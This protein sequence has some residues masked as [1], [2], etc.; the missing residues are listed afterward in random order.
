MIIWRIRKA[1][2]RDLR[3][4]VMTTTRRLAGLY[5]AARVAGTELGHGWERP[6]TAT[7]KTLLLLTPEVS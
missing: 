5:T 6:N 3:G 2:V 7:G 4:H 1:L